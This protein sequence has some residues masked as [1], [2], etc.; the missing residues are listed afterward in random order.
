MFVVTYM[1]RI[2]GL[3][4]TNSV[5]INQVIL[6]LLNA[7][8]L[9]GYDL[10]KRFSSSLLL[11]WSGNS[12]QIYRALSELHDQ[13]LV[14][15]EE[16]QQSNKPPRK[17]Y[18]LTDQGQQRLRDWLQSTPDVPQFQ[19][20][21]LIQLLWADQ[22]ERSASREVLEKYRAELN[23]HLTL[24][25]EYMRRETASAP[26]TDRESLAVRAMRHWIALYELHLTWV[27]DL[28]DSLALP[29]DKD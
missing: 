25:R 10:K 19:N 3:I 8:S 1:C 4:R 2:I 26:V 13:G 7:G 14:T 16:Q 24:L 27:D 20:P 21:L 28:V 29:E 17:L 18:T 11:P 9:T 22:I 23:E 15:V 6:G 12:N 5:L